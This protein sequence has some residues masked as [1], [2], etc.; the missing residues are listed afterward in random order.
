MVRMWVREKAV[1][2][3]GLRVGGKRMDLGGVQATSLPTL[4]DYGDRR[5]REEGAEE[6]RRIRQ[7]GWRVRGNLI[8]GDEGAKGLGYLEFAVDGGISRGDVQ[9]GSVLGQVP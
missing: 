8:Q 3:Q 5:E 6:A 4:G 9:V 1:L 7:P 2:G